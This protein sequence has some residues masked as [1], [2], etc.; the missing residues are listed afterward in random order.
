[1]NELDYPQLYFA[2]VAKTS[3]YAG[4]ILT[5]R[6]NT[7]QTNLLIQSLRAQL[8]ERNTEIIRLN[9]ENAMYATNERLINLEKRIQALE[10]HIVGK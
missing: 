2:E 5:L 10:C 7:E 3:H 4:E 9:R 1:M 8:A 6:K